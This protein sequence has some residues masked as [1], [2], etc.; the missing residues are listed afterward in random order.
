VA[1]FLS[2]TA[3][4]KQKETGAD[5]LALIYSPGG[6]KVAALFTRNKVKAAPVILSAKRAAGGSAGAII[7]NSGNAN[8][9]NGEEGYRDA[10]KTTEMAARALGISAEEVLVASTGVIGKRLNLEGIEEAVPSLAAGL[11]EGNLPRVA[12]AIMTTDTMPKLSR[13]EG[14]VAGRTFVVCGMG[15]GAGMMRPDMATMLVFIMTDLNI[16]SAALQTVL[17]NTVD[18]S[19]H[20]INIDGDTSTNDTVIALANGKAGNEVVGNDGPGL[21][22][23]QRAFDHV[24]NALARMLVF[25]GEGATKFVEIVIKGARND[26]Q[27][28]LAAHIV[29]ESKL[30]KTAFFGQ[31]ANWGRIMAALGRSGAEMEPEKVDIFIDDIV[32]VKNGLW[33]GKQAEE[34]ATARLKNR[35]FRVTADLN[36]GSGQATVYTSDLSL[37]Y[38]RINADYRS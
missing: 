4:S 23:V 14:V 24:G 16:E 36:L 5:D 32:L 28:R 17:A 29:A 37:D 21:D 22:E 11:E 6:A 35:E 18:R 30:V 19:F 25:D 31:D 27:A 1:G 38:V 12:R 15:K 34:N 33:A 13:C 10:L 7:V 20:R 3:S 9:C 8:A 2:A 26:E